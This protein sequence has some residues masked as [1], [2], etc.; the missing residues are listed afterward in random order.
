MMITPYAILELKSIRKY[1]VSNRFSKQYLRNQTIE[2]SKRL[3]NNK[4]SNE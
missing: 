1:Y 2:I 4:L 3:L